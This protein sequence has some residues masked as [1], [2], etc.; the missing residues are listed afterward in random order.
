MLM[1][2][3]FKV[4]ECCVDYGTPVLYYYDYLL[5]YYIHDIRYSV[6]YTMLSFAS[7]IS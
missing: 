4:T 1:Y 6:R 3:F 5:Q 2:Y 7:S